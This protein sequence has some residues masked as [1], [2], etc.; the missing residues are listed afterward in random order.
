[1]LTVKLIKH[2]SVYTTAR[3]SRVTYRVDVPMRILSR[4][5]ETISYKCGLLVPLCNVTGI[6]AAPSKGFTCMN[7]VLWI[8]KYSTPVFT[9]ISSPFLAMMYHVQQHNCS[10]SLHYMYD[11]EE[12]QEAILQSS[13]PMLLFAYTVPLIYQQGT[14]ETQNFIIFT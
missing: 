1:M 10:L 7:G 12:V 5:K 8:A 11:S 6:V 4:L 2:F 14:L 3:L 9:L 13:Q